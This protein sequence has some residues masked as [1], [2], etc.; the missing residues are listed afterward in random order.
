MWENTG[1]G[2]RS[3]SHRLN[4]E[5]ERE[6]ASRARRCDKDRERGGSGE[7]VGEF[8]VPVLA[9]FNLD[10]LSVSHSYGSDESR[11]QWCWIY[12]RLSADRFYCFCFY[13]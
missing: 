3:A 6:G 10:S 1:A 8:S 11:R 9:F 2:E 7:T 12:F 5:C 4:R 13:F